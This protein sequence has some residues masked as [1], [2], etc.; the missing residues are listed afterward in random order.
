MFN[1]TS[2]SS[3]SNDKHS[4]PHYFWYTLDQHDNIG[5]Y[6]RTPG[7]YL[8]PDCKVITPSL[9]QFKEQHRN[10]SQFTSSKKTLARSINIAASP[11]TQQQQHSSTIMSGMLQFW[12]I[13]RY[14]CNTIFT[15][16][17]IFRRQRFTNIATTSW[18]L[19]YLN[20]T[21][22]TACNN[23]NWWWRCSARAQHQRRLIRYVVY[24]H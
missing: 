21:T 17:T 12:F 23:S 3:S 2:S 6:Y 8:C 15:V 22:T 11:A 20:T 9:G 19:G 5:Q 24:N 10:A 1:N 14:T 4:T 18:W 16:I 7:G 13:T